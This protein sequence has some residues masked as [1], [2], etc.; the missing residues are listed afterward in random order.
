[1]IMKTL[2]S[3]SSSPIKVNILNCHYSIKPTENLTEADIRKLVDYVNGLMNQASQKG[4]DQLS[5]AVMVSL[6]LAAQ[7]YEEQNQ[8]ANAI[9]QLIQMMDEAMGNETTPMTLFES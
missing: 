2:D 9:R 7:M 5:V 3:H 4:Y 1:M 6:N 8:H